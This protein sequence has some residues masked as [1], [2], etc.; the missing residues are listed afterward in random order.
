MNDLFKALDDE[1]R[2]KILELLKDGDMTAGEISE[3]FKMSKPS[4][5]YHLELLRRGEL[6]NSSKKG[7]FVYYSL[8]T[9]VLDKVVRWLFKITKSKI[10]SEK[11]N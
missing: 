3:H 7:Q 8:N 10:I 9:S 2:R 5:S 6:V 11:N 4:I 1:S